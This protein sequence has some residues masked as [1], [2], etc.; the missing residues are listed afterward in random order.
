MFLSAKKKGLTH[1]VSNLCFSY[2]AEGGIRTLV[3]FWHK[4]ISSQPRYDR[5]D[6]S[7]YKKHI[8]FY[9]ILIENCL[10]TSRKSSL[11]IPK[12]QGFSRVYMNRI[13][14]KPSFFR[15]SPVMTSSI[16]LHRYDATACII[17]MQ[18]PVRSGSRAQLLNPLRISHPKIDKL[19]CHAQGAD[20][21]TKGEISLYDAYCVHF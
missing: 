10:L 6:T 19:A 9:G 11:Q 3:C 5:F 21:F 13:G 2:G 18:R 12:K 20:I 1:F 15:V 14:T 7:A 8:K 4:L 17:S 16:P